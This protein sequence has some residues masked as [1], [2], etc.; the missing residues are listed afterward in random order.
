M[1]SICR[2]ACRIHYTHCVQRVSIHISDSGGPSATREPALLRES[3]SALILRPVLDVTAAPL[4]RLALLYDM[5]L[6]GHIAKALHR[7][8]IWLSEARIA[9]VDTLARSVWLGSAHAFAADYVE[10][11]KSATRPVMQGYCALCEAASPFRADGSETA[12]EGCLRRAKRKSAEC[13]L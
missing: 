11:L 5:S 9:G 7:H 12:C 13:W 1:P 6:T 2:C 3:A 8:F 10:G 4:A